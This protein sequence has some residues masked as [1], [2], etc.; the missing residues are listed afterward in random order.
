MFAIKKINIIILFFLIVFLSC[1]E[2]QPFIPEDMPGSIVGLVKPQGINAQIN[3]YQ[4]KLVQSVQS[5]SITGYFEILNIDAGVYN[6]EFVADNYGRYIL[7]EVIV[8][9]NK[10]TATPDIYLNQFPEQILFVNPADNAANVPVTFPIEI[11]FSFQMNQSSVENN[12]AIQPVVNG[13]F[14]WIN[15]A[16]QHKMIFHPSDQYATNQSYTIQLNKNAETIYGDT[17]FFSV[18]SHFTTENIKIISTIPEDNA[19]YISPQTEIYI[20]FNSKMDRESVESKI[21]MTPS[22]NGD[23]RWLDSKRVSFKPDGFLASNTEYEIIIFPGLMDIYGS[24]FLTGK[25]F[26]FKTEPLKVV[27]NYPSN[28]ATYVNTSSPIVITFNTYM[29]QAAAESS[30][31]ITPEVDDWHF[32]WSDLTRFQFFGTTKLQTNTQYTV[33]IDSSCADYWN[34]KLLSEFSFNFMTG[35]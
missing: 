18:E 12:F 13:Y 2:E 21:A 9:P 35:E 22:T 26:T 25:S 6:L 4:G 10:A 29:N 31:T 14:E 16:N 32:Q 27:S 23:F 30:F 5:D 15:S 1:T 19:T 20:S 28:G 3:L 34:N 11:E 7:N 8:Y 17:L 33:T 24:L